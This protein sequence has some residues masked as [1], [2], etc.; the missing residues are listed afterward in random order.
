MGDVLLPKAVVFDLDGTLIDSRGDIVAALNHALI[1]TGRNPQP[2]STIVQ[3][4][5]NGARSLC[6]QATAQFEDDPETDELVQ[7]FLEYYQA[8]P[9]DFTR[10]APGALQA[11]D[12][13]AL[14]D[15][16]LIGL[17]TNKHR[18]TTEAVLDALGIRDRF[19][20][21]VAG[22]DLP[23]LKPDPAPL[24]LTA[25]LLGVD[26]RT[27]V[28]VGDGVQD[29]ECAKNAGAW[30]V[31]IESGFTPADELMMASPNVAVKDLSVVARVVQR[32]REPTTR[33]KLR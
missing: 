13:L 31:A 6:A 5:G 14:M 8:H 21:V 19:R 18:S 20:A 4:V 28:M 22:G 29:V 1:S 30:S 32:W 23:E 27:V 12:D 26:P 11:L 15:D 17:C 25:K 2:A 10:W 16:M 7:L 9:L 3:L 24:L 33:L